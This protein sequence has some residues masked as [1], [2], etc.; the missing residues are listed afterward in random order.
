V[1]VYALDTNIVSYLLKGNAKITVK[2][3]KE[4]NDGN[5]FVIPPI[6]YYEINNW[7]LKNNSKR[8]A[9]IFKKICSVNGIGPISKE[10]LDIASSIYDNLRKNGVVIETADLLIAAWCIKNNCTLIS[11]NKKHFNRIDLLTVENWLE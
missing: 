9:A 10:V 6:V 7:L 2:M 8:K 11:N 3:A 1:K 4:K 5:T